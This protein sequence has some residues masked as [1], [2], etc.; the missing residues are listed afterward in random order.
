MIKFIQ[1]N[2]EPIF[3]GS[4]GGFGACLCMGD[5]VACAMYVIVSIVVICIKYR[6]ENV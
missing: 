6:K 2:F 1:N 3:Y 5:F 4:A